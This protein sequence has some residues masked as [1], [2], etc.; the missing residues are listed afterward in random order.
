MCACVR[1][2]LFTCPT[3]LGWA[4]KTSRMILPTPRSTSS[5]DASS[6]MMTLFSIRNLRLPLCAHT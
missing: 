3:V 1:V 4:S 6:P 5:S 2:S